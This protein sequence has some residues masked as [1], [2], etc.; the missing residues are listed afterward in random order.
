MK[1]G[2]NN[3]SRNDPIKTEGLGVAERGAESSFSA[4]HPVV[5][6][7]TRGRCAR[8]SCGVQPMTSRA[9]HLPRDTRR[10]DPLPTGTVTML[11]TDIEGST[12]LLSRLGDRY[13]GALS[14]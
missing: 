5:D 1:L 11:F 4:R 12:A 6:E 14:T 8:R 13:G 9:R 3:S 7:A 10:M 2:N